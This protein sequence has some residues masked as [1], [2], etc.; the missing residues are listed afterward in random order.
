MAQH[1]EGAKG[2]QFAVGGV[3]VYLAKLGGDPFQKVLFRTLRVEFAVFLPLFALSLLDET[4]QV[5]RVQCQLP[6]V[7]GG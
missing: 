1:A 5:F 7:T 3:G 2:A 6:V 4:E